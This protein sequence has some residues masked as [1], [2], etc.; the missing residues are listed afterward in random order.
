MQQPV[1]SRRLSVGVVDIHEELGN[2]GVELVKMFN[3]RW[4]SLRLFA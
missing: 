4:L 2:I 1:A 3:L